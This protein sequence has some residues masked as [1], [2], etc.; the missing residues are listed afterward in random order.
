MYFIGYDAGSSSVKAA[1]INA[2][3]GQQIAVVQSPATEMG[4]ESPQPGWAEQDPAI[5]WQH[6]CLATRQLLQQ[7][8]V[9]GH[10][11]AGVGISYQMHG[12]VA[13]DRSG[14][15]LRPAIIWCDS[16]AVGIGEKAFA[17]LG[18]RQCLSR[19]LNAPGNFTASKLRWVQENEPDLYRH[20]H[21]FMLPGDYL[22]MR[23]S[24]EI[25]T[26]SGG[27][28]EGILWDYPAN[29]PANLLLAHYDM[30]RNLVP[31]LVE[32]FQVQG[33]ISIHAA[34]EL[35]LPAGI[36]LTYR[37]GDQ[38][39]NALA[40]NVLHPGTA[41]AT[42]GTSG[43]VYGVADAPVFDPQSRVNA[44]LHV[45]HTTAVPRIG[46]L[47]CLN[48][49]GILY[50]WIRQVLGGTVSYDELEKL[51][52][53]VQIGSDGLVFLPFGNGAER[54]LGNTDPGARLSGLQFN[55][56]NREQ[57]VRAGL[58]G[59]A[60]ALAY[61]M[62]VMRGMGLQLEVLRV[63]NDNL[64]R[65]AIF[66]TTLANCTGSRIEV[67][68]TTGAYGAARAAAAG[69]GAFASLEEAMGTLRAVNAYV[70]DETA[71]AKQA[72]SAWKREL[73]SILDSKPGIG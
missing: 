58:E 36:P 52:A 11:V 1:L 41:A 24:G 68:D 39:N 49:A 23:M 4:I 17:A 3:N 69:S 51:A 27:L 50:R 62:E 72:F 7:S 5:W 48:G 12:L 54:M 45:N 55:R 19:L 46:I 42:G 47:L 53:K 33:R 31:D 6:L 13:V 64:F 32:N 26:T 63:G 29:S 16:R 73:N 22:A 34:A 14:N 18:E 10:D 60:F 56:H 9:K 40:L 21:K 38:P 28:S 66:S 30:D 43:V 35:G 25:S 59:V 70:P 61:G 65:S 2:D 20:I 67:F 57:L 71:I 15:P 37:A 44:F 8:G